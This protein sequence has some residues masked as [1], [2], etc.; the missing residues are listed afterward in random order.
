MPFPPPRLAAALF[1]FVWCSFFPKEVLGENSRDADKDWQVILEGAKG[2]GLQYSSQD[3]AL[4]MAGQH[5]AKQEGELRAFQKDY[6][7]DSRH[8]S[9][10][11]RLAD[12]LAAEGRLKRDRSD[13][14]TAREILAKLE[15]DPE[16]PQLVKADAGFARVSQAMQDA[17]GHLDVSTR[18]TLLV[19]I[20]QFDAAYPGDR[21]TGN[22]LTEIA[23]LYDSDPAQKKSLLEE[24]LGRTK[25]ENVRSRIND[26]LKRISLL[27]K[28]I[29]LRLQPWDGRPAIDLAQHRGRAQVILFWASY[30]LPALN[31]LAVLQRAASGFEGQ[32][33]DFLTV[34]LDEDRNALA[35]TIK[36][37]NLQ[38]PTQSDGKGWKGELVRSLGINALPTVWVLDRQGRLLTLNARGEE[39][40]TIHR[41]LTASSQ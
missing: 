39:T 7:A 27:G 31:E 32:P 12:V 38:W 23:T 29:D 3:E 6:P 24:A 9:A 8:Y 15:G 26:D 20:R 25:D 10:V 40:E 1:L 13:A 11:I 19:T 33:V 2:P 17:A 18:D 37:S 22:L 30:S 16:T 21:R 28:P 36:I 4:K 35:G 41:A 14:D 34:S 5:L